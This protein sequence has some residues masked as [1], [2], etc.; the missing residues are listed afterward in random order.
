MI[1]QWPIQ[2]CWV[3]GLVFGMGWLGCDSSSL[4]TAFSPCDPGG[5]N[6]HL[7]DVEPSQKGQSCHGIFQ[8]NV[9]PAK[10][11][12]APPLD[13]ETLSYTPTL[14][15]LD[16]PLL[17]SVQG[18]NLRSDSMV[19]IGVLRKRRGQGT[20]PQ[21]PTTVTQPMEPRSS[22][23]TSYAVRAYVPSWQHK[24]APYRSARFSIAFA[25]GGLDLFRA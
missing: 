15:A 10:P 6:P 17:L 4:T 13:P 20:P 11:E 2:A 23:W 21:C 22:R 19:R 12:Q 9:V 18:K 7:G 16:G 8:A 5:E 24:R 14:A 3:T 25:E 1:H